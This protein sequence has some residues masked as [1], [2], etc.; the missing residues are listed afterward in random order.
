M[1][2]REAQIGFSVLVGA[3]LGALPIGAKAGPVEENGQSI[4]E[5]AVT[6]GQCA[7]PAHATSAVRTLVRGRPQAGR[8]RCSHPEGRL[9]GPRLVCRQGPPDFE[10]GLAT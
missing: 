2:N 9:H 10:S 1:A 8:R 4:G 7:G 3:H 5:T 6:P